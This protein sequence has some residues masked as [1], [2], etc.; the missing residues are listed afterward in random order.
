MSPQ[1]VFRGTKRAH[2]PWPSLGLHCGYRLLRATTLFIPLLIMCVFRTRSMSPNPCNLYLTCQ[3]LQEGISAQPSTQ[4]YEFSK[5]YLTYG[6]NLNGKSC[7]ELMCTSI[8]PTSVSVLI[9]LFQTIWEN[10]KGL[11]AFT[12]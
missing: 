9:Y 10:W 6:W 2:T 7:Q 1:Y 5:P 4:T 8:K 3:N 12:D 11:L